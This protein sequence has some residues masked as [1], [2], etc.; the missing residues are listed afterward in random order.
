MLLGKGVTISNYEI[1]DGVEIDNNPQK[2]PEILKKIKEIKSRKKVVDLP[3]CEKGICK[4]N[5][6]ISKEFKN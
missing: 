3:L 6:E 2:E 1:Y 4:P 5:V